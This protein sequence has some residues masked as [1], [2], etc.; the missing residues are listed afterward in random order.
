MLT[1]ENVKRK[2]VVMGGNDLS[3]FI[4]IGHC[5]CCGAITP[6]GVHCL[7]CRRS[8]NT[9]LKRTELIGFL[10]GSNDVEM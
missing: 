6:Y 4:P 8:F 7:S 2:L 1:T 3:K 5:E 10:R 9:M